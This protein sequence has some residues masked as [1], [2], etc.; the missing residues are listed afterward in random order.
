MQE[1]ITALTQLA[2]D[3][4]EHSARIKAA[5][6]EHFP[7]QK[8]YEIWELEYNTYKGSGKCWIAEID[9]ETKEKLSFLDAKSVEKDGTYKGKKTYK[10]PLI[11]GK[12][13]QFRESDTKSV[14]KNYYRIVRDGKLEPL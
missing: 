12:A 5:F 7:E 13:Y 8:G 1:F 3:Y 4:P 14:D 2:A 9:P 11:E 6:P 10:V